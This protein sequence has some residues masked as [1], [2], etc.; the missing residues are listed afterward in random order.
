MEV[1]VKVLLI[2]SILVGFCKA[3]S[4]PVLNVRTIIQEP[5]IIKA[6]DGKDSDSI[7]GYKGILI[8]M[9]LSFLENNNKSETVKFQVSKE[10][11]S[12]NKDGSWTGII[13]DMAK[14]TKSIFG[15]ADVT[16]NSDRMDA[17]EFS[18]PFYSTGLSALG[19]GVKFPINQDNLPKLLKMAE[20]D[21]ITVGCQK[22]VA[23]EHF[24]KDTDIPIYKQLWEQM[25]KSNDNFVKSMDE[26]VAK[27]R[28]ASS[29]KPY[30]FFA[31]QA[32]LDYYAGQAPCELHSTACEQLNALHLAI[33]FNKHQDPDTINLYNKQIA[34]YLASGK[35]DMSINKWYKNECGGNKTMSH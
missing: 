32:N 16:V 14:D 27:V 15:L 25:K 12:K 5:F 11:G 30:V 8:D 28:K 7:S 13:G 2:T 34:D 22:D 21:K 10:Y 24:F 9:L 17:V 33:V 29:D 23:T 26:G 20:D 18:L 6:E 4:Q 35:L 19:K 31:E 3:D 1:T